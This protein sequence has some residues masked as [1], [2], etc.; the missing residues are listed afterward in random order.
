M[1]RRS[2]DKGGER[3]RREERRRQEEGRAEE[4][5]YGRMRRDEGGWMT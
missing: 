3:S 2:E 4:E 5:G 1:R